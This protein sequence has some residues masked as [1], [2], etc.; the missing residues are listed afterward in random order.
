MGSGYRIQLEGRVS[1][2]RLQDTTRGQ[3][4]VSGLWLQDTTRGQGRVSGLSYKIQLGG[5]TW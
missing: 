5:R 3:G 1:G 4:R 2:L